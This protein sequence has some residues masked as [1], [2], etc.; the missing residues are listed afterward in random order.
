MQ[1]RG[2]VIAARVAYMR[3]RGLPAFARFLTSLTDGARAL[4]DGGLRPEAF[5]PVEAFYEVLETIDRLEGQG[6]LQLCFDL[7]KDACDRNLGTFHRFFLRWSSIHQM[8]DRATAAWHV[9][10]QGAELVV[11]DR[12]ERHVT[13]RIDDVPVPHRGF[14][15]SVKGWIVRMG[16]HTGEQLVPEAETCRAEGHDECAMTF[17]W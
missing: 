9:H 15:L 7:G 12:S 4:C 5:Y 13:L 10:Y 1:V 6:D 16:E 17:R 3:G 11:V 14:C 2:S 8:I